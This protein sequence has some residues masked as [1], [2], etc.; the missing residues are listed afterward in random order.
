VTTAAVDLGGM[1]LRVGYLGAGG[2][3]LVPAAD[4]SD[5]VPAAVWLAAPGDARA[6][7]LAAGGP[8]A[9]VVT[10][11]R[12]DLR[13]DPRAGARDRYFHGRFESPVA[14]AGYLLAD[15]ARRA[16][17]ASGSDVMS[18]VL[19]RPVTIDD[20]TPLRRAAAAARLTVTGIIAEP[21]AV[22]LHYGAVADGVDHVTVVADLGGTAT[23][24]TVLRIRGRVVTIEA[25]ARQPAQAGADL[26]AR[27]TELVRQAIGEAGGGPGGRPDTVLL[28]GGAGRRPDV[29]DALAA[30]LCLHVRA[31]QPE[32]AVVRG[33]AL[34]SD[35]GLLYVT[36]LGGDP[37]SPPPPPPSRVISP[38]TAQPS[39]PAGTA[40]AV[41]PQPRGADP[42]PAARPADVPA[43]DPL[44]RATA[45]ADGADSGPPTHATV[46][47]R[48]RP[49]PA[50]PPPPPPPPRAHQPTPA[51]A[52]PAPQAPPP[53]AVR[54][55][56]SGD[57][58][59][60]PGDV[61]VGGTPGAR[62]LTGRPVERLTALRRGE[63]VLLTWDWPNGTAEA[64]VR[65]RSDADHPGQHGSA[66]CTRRR[67][68][69]EG[70]FEIPA[71][72]D[73]V[74]ITVEALGYGE[75]FDG[76]PP[77]ALRVDPAPAAVTY[78]PD[79][80]GWR[81]WIATVTFAS[82][83]DCSLPSVFAVLGT[84]VY[85]PESTRDG[86][87]VQVIPAQKLSAGQP[88]TV[89]FELAPR[90]GIC[91]LVCVPADDDTVAP[92]DLRPASLHRLR[93]RG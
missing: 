66:R 92:V 19:G 86:T 30:Q 50:A 18:V 4:G 58:E 25:A 76:A 36:G 3:T 23:D 28:A 89:T 49:R 10:T 88:A 15:A 37:L 78:D 33:L 12:A 8:A 83:V 57:A 26:P 24:V 2:V 60:A 62:Q 85:K 69:H 54:A 7:E 91:W 21:V 67:Y 46:P 5:A 52:P 81:K 44:P 74:M 22:A 11:V 45:A 65:W 17:L 13:A 53:A 93:V 27:V 31:S 29:A 87:V 51:P 84:G 41:D 80:Q 16:A 48:A 82:Q 68:N 39:G 73:G 61:P 72:S 90:R 70:G 79:V 14:V 47:V 43:A 64:Q 35:F 6:G 56:D 38:A 9:D 40:P 20:T 75:Q 77:S 71:G 1:S 55:A 63:R 59:R 34:S 32:A 42:E